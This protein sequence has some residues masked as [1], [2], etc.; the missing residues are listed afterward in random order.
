MRSKKLWL[1]LFLLLAGTTLTGC[2]FITKLRA[3]DSLNKGVRAFTEQ[4]YDEAA[5]YFE[6]AIRLD[7]QFPVARMYLATTYTSQFVPGSPDPK[8]AEM[9]DKAI[10][11]FKGVLEADKA[12]PNI[13]AMLSIASLYYQLKRYDDS[14]EWCAKIQQVDPQNAEALYRVAVIDFDDSLKKTGLQGENVEFLG[15][16]ERGH[17]L[18]DIE[19]GLKALERAIQL[20]PD[21]FDAMEYQN[22]LLREKAKFEKSE[23]AKAEL[24]R[25]A[26]KVAQR[27]LALRLRAQEEEAKK[28]KKGA[29]GP[30][31]L[32]CTS[33]HAQQPASFFPQSPIP[34]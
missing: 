17:T 33:L 13:N 8:S 18:A 7:P 27:A 26:D 19:E 10:E 15:T 31:F 32:L 3:R 29:G 9:A 25:E 6:E 1:A 20:K 23:K 11:T 12:N 24:I 22:L 30:H 28:P 21:Y 4:K 2:G 16:E 34:L 5:K 14:K